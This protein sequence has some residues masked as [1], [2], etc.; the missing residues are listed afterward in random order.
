MLYNTIII[1]TD[2]KSV[3]SIYGSLFM[4][5]MFFLKLKMSRSTSIYYIL[6]LGGV[7]GSSS[8]SGII[9]RWCLPESMTINF[10]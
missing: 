6:D 1:H 3:I 10:L 7:G 2:L 4:R 9:S 8:I 5:S